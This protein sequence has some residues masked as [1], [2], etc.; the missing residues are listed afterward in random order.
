M[1]IVT[2]LLMQKKNKNRVNLFLDDEYFCSL[3]AAAAVSARIKVGDNADEAF[4]KEVIFKSE[5]ASALDRA[6]K[7]LGI[8]PSSKRK[9]KEYLIEKG[10]DEDVT[11]AVIERLLQLNYLND[12]AV[13]AGYVKSCAGR[14]GNGILR[15]K[16]KERGIG[17]D[18]IA[19]VLPS[20]GEEAEAAKNLAVKYL[21]QNNPDKKKLYGYLF[22]KGFSSEAI[23]E[24]L[25]M[26][27]EEK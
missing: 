26:I 24:A 25:R 18:I 2:A 12:N 4:L 16:L 10:Y 19:G 23:S 22:N 7:Y 8:K 21:D 6:L 11:Q 20:G 14:Y 17:S 3:D 9:I 13:A 5:Y 27:K 15:L 1:A